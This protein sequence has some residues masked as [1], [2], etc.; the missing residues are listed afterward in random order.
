[1]FSAALLLPNK[2]APASANFSQK[3]SCGRIEKDKHSYNK[4]T[5]IPAEMIVFLLIIKIFGD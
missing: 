4:K 5:I 1:L 3:T 2:T